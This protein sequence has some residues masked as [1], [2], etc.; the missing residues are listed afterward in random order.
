MKVI[1]KWKEKPLSY[2]IFRENQCCCNR[3]LAFLT[4]SFLDN[5]CTGVSDTWYTITYAMHLLIIQFLQYANWSIK[6]IVRDYLINQIGRIETDIEHKHA[7][8]MRRYYCMGIG[9]VLYDIWLPMIHA[10]DLSDQG[11][12]MTGSRSTNSNAVDCIYKV[13]RVIVCAVCL[14]FVFILFI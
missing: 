14:W 1:T 11:R 7:I 8:W 6:S 3:S 10:R 13:N 9:V 5:N 12:L 2:Y 4:Y